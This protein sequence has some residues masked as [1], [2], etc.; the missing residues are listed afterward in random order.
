MIRFWNLD[1]DE[2][3]VLT[4]FDQD[5]RNDKIHLIQF[6]NK[7]KLMI[8]GTQEGK[9]VFWKN[10][11]EL[12]VDSEYWKVTKSEIQ[13]Q[14]P[15]KDLCVGNGLIVAKYDQEILFV[16]ENSISARI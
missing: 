14:G 16:Q 10:R 13:H 8:G 5:I 15:V 6:E 9:L 2:N 4:L 3:Y 11:S 12:F 1:E 7:S